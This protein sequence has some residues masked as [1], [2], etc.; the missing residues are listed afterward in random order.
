MKYL[1]RV[2]DGQ[3]FYWNTCGWSDCRRTARVYPV[4]EAYA[5]LQ[6]MERD[7]QRVHMVPVW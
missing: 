4:Y 7:G 2:I 3:N 5:T 6:R 1:V